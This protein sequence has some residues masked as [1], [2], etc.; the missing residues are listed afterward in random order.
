MRGVFWSLSFAGWISGAAAAGAAD[1]APSHYAMFRADL[2]TA[3]VSAIPSRP[4]IFR[5]TTE[6]PVAEDGEP[7]PYGRIV[8]RPPISRPGGSLSDGEKQSIGCLAAGTAGMGIAM[9]AD[10]TNVIN[11]IAGGLVFPANQAVLYISL[12]GVVF[13]SFCAVGQA[14]TPAVLMAYD[15]YF[16]TD[17][18]ISLPVRKVSPLH[19]ILRVSISSPERPEFAFAPRTGR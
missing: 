9:A 5:T 6:A 17:S 15:R 10:G 13:A 4:A 11:V 12:V 14:L 8:P 16:E 2:R 3:S 1:M 18:P 19:S 7:A